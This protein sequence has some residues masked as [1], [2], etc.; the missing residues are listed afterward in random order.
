MFNRRIVNY[1][2]EW[3]GKKNRKPLVLRGAR[4]VG[5]TSAVK[6]FAREC[7][8][9]FV[10]INLESA[11]DFEVFKDVNTLD[12]F[13][14]I[15][16][17]VFGKEIIAGSTLIFID[18][19]QNA[20][21]LIELLRFFYEEKP[22]LHIVVAGSLLDVKIEKQGLTMPV[23]RIEYAY[24]FPLTFFEFLEAIK[25]EKL[26]YFLRDCDIKSKIPAA[27]HRRAL[28]FFQEYALIG[29]MP[30]AVALY[31]QKKWQKEINTV[32]SSLLT[33]YNED[34]YK[35]S[36]AADVKYVS[37]A[38]EQ[39]PYFAGERI[40][41]EKFGGSVYKSREMGDAFEVLE[42]AMLLNQIRTTKSVDLPLIKQEKR[43]KK[44]LY[45]DVG[46]VNFKNN[47][48]VK[49]LQIKDL[50]DL[51][52][53]K[54]AE[55]VVG[56]NLIADKVNMAQTLFYWARERDK[57][58]AE[59]DFCLVNKGKIIG[60]EVKSGHSMKLRSLFSFGDSVKNSVLIRVYSGELKIEDII[61]ARKKYKLISVPFYLVNNIK[62][63]V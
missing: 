50:N 39:A 33:A 29:G 60:I 22:S 41:Y 4:Q 44:L 5:K 16:D 56:Q 57:S 55:Q 31:Q 52:R 14:R 36:S 32:Y 9:H 21:N 15:T 48:Q 2:K 61:Y 47:V 8:E 19:I 35:Y 34:I 26:L 59:V 54:I 20:P 53:G 42:K 3:K 12:D 28:D 11:K 13:E 30:E 45:L 7:F 27:I 6:I 51:Y 1:L 40:V 18:E 49:F 63:M 43:S 58:S 23:G 38:L 37:Y 62:K 10:Y 25:E 46:L 17:V 24:V